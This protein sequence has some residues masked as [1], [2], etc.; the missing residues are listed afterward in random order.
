MSAPSHNP[1]HVERFSGFSDIYDRYRPQP[2]AVLIDLLAQLAG[3]ERPALVVDVG[4]GTGLSTRLWAGH[5]DQAIGIEPNDDMRDQ[6]EAQTV[7]P[8]VRY[9]PGFSTATGLPDACADI[10]TA[11]QALH[12]MEPEPTLAE[13]ARIL[14]PGGVFAAFD[15][16]WP[17]AMHWEAEAA[18]EAC[19]A[20]VREVNRAHGLTSTVKAWPKHE[21][22]GWMRAS[23]HF[24][25]TRE[26]VLHSVEPGNAERL[27]G[28]ALS[29]GHVATPLKHGL[30]EDE[31]GLAELRAVAARTLGDEPRPWYFSY[32]VRLGIT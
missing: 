11:S 16:D 17:P 5:A 3:V 25:Y 4:S 29:Q 19:M 2:P 9:Q 12:W 26:V 28:L 6:A 22:L 10:V 30:S 31:L 7:A 14:R 27:V 20:R 15:C 24:R 13:M 1:A 8:G 23:G 18:Y 21:H 32:R